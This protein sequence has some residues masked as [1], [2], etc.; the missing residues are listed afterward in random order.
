MIGFQTN[1]KPNQSPQTG[2]QAKLEE[3][4]KTQKKIVGPRPSKDKWTMSV[5]AA[6]AL[7][8]VRLTSI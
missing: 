2:K 8:E 4:N 3:F 1:K 7:E 5:A 6:P